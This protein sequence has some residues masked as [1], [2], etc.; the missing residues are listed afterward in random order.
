MY[1]KLSGAHLEV[2]PQ[3]YTSE[4]Q[5]VRSRLTG[6]NVEISFLPLPAAADPSK[7][8]QVPANPFVSLKQEGYMHMHPE[9]L[10][11]T[12]LAE[13]DRETKGHHLPE[14]VKK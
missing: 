9:V 11:K 8:G 10:G 12:A 7:G 14:K 13:W 5:T 1:D 4:H 6:K 3:D 2:K